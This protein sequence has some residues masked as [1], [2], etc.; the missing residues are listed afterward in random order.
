MQDS[1]ISVDVH[2]N[3]PIDDTDPDELYTEG[4]ECQRQFGGVNIS[5]LLCI[6]QGIFFS[7]AHHRGMR[8]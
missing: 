5:Q 8:G 1:G 2:Q 7:S 6:H 4:Y 3:H